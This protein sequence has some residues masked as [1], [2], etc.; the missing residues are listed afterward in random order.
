M[1]QL[2]RCIMNSYGRYFNHKYKRSGSLYESRYKA[3]LI[4]A[5][6]YL[7]HISRYIHLNPRYWL[8]YKYSSISHYL[9]NLDDE[10]LQKRRITELFHDAQDYRTFLEDYEDHKSMLEELKYVLAD[11]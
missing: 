4:D 6:N 2:M 9:N 8:R 11:L 7:L 10:W 5:D 1:T 3:S